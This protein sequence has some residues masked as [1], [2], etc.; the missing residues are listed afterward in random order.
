[1]YMFSVYQVM[2]IGV[3][4]VTLPI[5]PSVIVF[6]LISTLFTLTSEILMKYSVL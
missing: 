5:F 3:R 2:T 6:L 1:M 4:K